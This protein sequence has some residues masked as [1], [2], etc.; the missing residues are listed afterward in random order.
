MND[1]MTSLE[2]MSASQEYEEHE[3]EQVPI[4]PWSPEAFDEIYCQ[5]SIR[6]RPHTSLGIEREED[7]DDE[8]APVKLYPNGQDESDR[9]DSYVQRMENRLNHIQYHD[10]DHYDQDNGAKL[11]S[12]TPPPPTRGVSGW[13]RPGSSYSQS[14][15]GSSQADSSRPS[16]S[17]ATSQVGPGRQ[18][19]LRSRKSAYELGRARLS[20]S[21]T[22]KSSVTTASSTAQST[23]TNNSHSTQATSQSL[24]S[25]YSAGGFSA[26]SAGSLARRKFGRNGSVKE[27][28]RPM[29][30][31][32]LQTVTGGMSTV[33]YHSSHDSNP[34]DRLTVEPESAAIGGLLGGLS[35]PISS[36]SKKRSFLG[37]MMDTVKTGAANARSNMSEKSSSRPPSRQK[38]FVSQGIS[39][40]SS[41]P[42]SR[43]AANEMGLSGTSDWVNM[44]RDVNRSNSLSRNE[45]S[46]RIERCQMLDLPVLTP[47]ETLN[48]SVQGNEG[49]DGEPL[50]ESTDIASC[51]FSMV[52]KS[53]RF[54]SNLPALINSSS[55]A[56]GYLCRQYKS[57]V[58]RLRAMFTWVCER[59]TWED[60]FEGV[61][62]TRRVI[63]SKR[64]CSEEI[65]VLVAE[66]CDAIGIHAEIIR[67]HLK[68]PG[69]LNL[70]Q[71]LNDAAAR[72]NHWWNAVIADGEWRILDC[73]LANPTNPRRASYSSVGNQMAESWWFLA[74]PT[75][76][77]YTHVPLLPEQQHMVPPMAHS[78]LMAL[79][80]A[81]PPYFKHSLQMWDFDTSLLNLEG[82]EMAHIQL[83]V[84]EDIECIATVTTRSFARDTDGDVFESGDYITK[85]ALAQGDFISVD[86][87]S[88]GNAIKRYTIKAL[89][90]STSEDS[91]PSSTPSAST[92][93]LNIYAGRRGLMHSIN[94]NPH[95]LAL[96]LPLVL[97]GGQN[98]DY[99]FFTRHPT[100]HALRHEL[101]V[102]GPLCK[103]LAF[104]NTFVFG[105]RQH[106]S[107]ANWTS[108]E[109]RPGSPGLRAGSAMAIA[110]PGSAMSVASVSASGSAYSDGSSSGNGVPGLLGQQKSA[111]LA[112]QSP[113][114]KILRMT[115]KTEVRGRG[116]GYGV[117]Q[118][119]DEDGVVKVGSQ[120]ET[121]IKIGERGTWRALVLAD[122]SARWCVFGEWECF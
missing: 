53:A 54:V 115:R 8:G 35:A 114:G 64:G 36:P 50:R 69:E 4:N 92:A 13:G 3:K 31:M 99:E 120:W 77:C 62:D 7:E 107:S 75:E 44:R 101:Y 16:S 76:I 110:R 83:S 102:T 56:Q 65:A 42:A 84:P 27:Q 12:P 73:A 94:N 5:D 23:S 19:T 78:I 20:R 112:V 74:R 85:R 25:G 66:M 49:A 48:D 106:P 29:S 118:S 37:K 18:N 105:V 52:D 11:E 15:P 30:A 82:L 93:T 60:D 45:R 1:V 41:R 22:N 6:A 103:R 104:N 79:P 98:P 33:S 88:S 14:R 97:H 17:H 46:E 72:P 34:S 32:G 121:I 70:N 113:S 81:S 28:L 2:G 122:R 119:T 89:V 21:F 59:V 108:V 39:S 38:N 61:V 109:K 68:I 67:G 80:I 40:E 116:A 90:P 91:T 9:L 95:S 117:G 96:S 58:Q 55:L 57:D 10:Q 24:M 51:N 47:V 111:K 63:Q 86:T 100:P 87:L 43:S 71:D 26:T